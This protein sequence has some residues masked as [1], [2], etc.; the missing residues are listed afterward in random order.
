M[1]VCGAYYPTGRHRPALSGAYFGDL[2]SCVKYEGY[3]VKDGALVR[4]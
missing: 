3:E 4:E 2:W 1:L